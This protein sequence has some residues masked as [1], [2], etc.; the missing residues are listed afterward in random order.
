MGFQLER[1]AVSENDYYFFFAKKK[2]ILFKLD[3]K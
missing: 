3:T 1:P 2:I